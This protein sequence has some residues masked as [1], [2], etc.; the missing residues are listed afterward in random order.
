MSVANSHFDIQS[1]LNISLNIAFSA[2]EQC[3]SGPWIT[4]KAS[5]LTVVAAFWMRG[6]CQ[7]F[8]LGYRSQNPF[9]Q[10]QTMAMIVTIPPPQ[11]QTNKQEALS[12][13]SVVEIFR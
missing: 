9:A 1:L 13:Q 2:V 4:L 10:S 5:A 11:K 3:L 7:T 8:Q 12:V 6:C